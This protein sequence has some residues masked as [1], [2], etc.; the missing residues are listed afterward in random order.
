M[1]RHL[2]LLVVLLTLAPSAI[3]RAADSWIFRSSHYSHDPETGQR[4]AQYAPKQAAYRTVDPT[5]VQSGYRH[6]R[7][8]LRGVGGSVDRRHI[9]ETWGAGEMIRPY[10][11]WQYPYRAG[12]T[13]FGPW[14]SAAGPWTLPFD[15]WNNPYGLLNQ[16][17]GP[18]PQWGYP[19]PVPYAAPHSGPHATPHPAPHQGGPYRMTPQFS[20]PHQSG[21]HP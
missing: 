12:A 11:E 9:V 6:S 20:P 4:V 15:S 21:G 3:G 5:Y 18:Y 13:P 2:A 7:S 14:G 16:R 19:T 8:T 1:R 10:G 17:H